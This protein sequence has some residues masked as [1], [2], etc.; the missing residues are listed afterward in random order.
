MSDDQGPGPARTGPARTGPV[1]TEQASVERAKGKQNGRGALI[2]ARY[3]TDLQNERSIEDQIRLCRPLVKDHETLAGTCQDRARSGAFIANRP[4]LKTVLDLIEANMV[5]VLIAENLDRISRNLAEMA[6]IF[7]LAEF[8]GTSIRTLH[9]GEIGLLQI[10]LGGVMNEIEIRKTS[11]R[12]R[13]GQTG[14]ILAGRAAGDL[15]YGYAIDPFDNAGMRATGHRR[16]V[17]EQAAIIRRIFADYVAGKPV[18]A[19]A[20]T[21]T[22][23]GVPGPRGGVWYASFISGT[24][25]RRNGI[26]LNPIYIG[27]L[28]WNRNRTVRHPDTGKA[29]TRQNDAADWTVHHVPELRIIDDATWQ[30]AQ[31]RRLG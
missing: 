20:R 27:Q 7:R 4:G 2:Y 5:S 18:K 15:P 8:H 25:A 28:V 29:A 10:G 9:E 23:E 12:T 6:R 13:R 26:I 3:S 14:S 21:L 11:A 1:A 16:I 22:A 19:I 24:V 17:P 30:A 31:K